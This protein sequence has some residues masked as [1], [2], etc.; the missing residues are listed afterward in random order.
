MN[1]M[2]Y[3][4][5]HNINIIPQ[6]DYEALVKETFNDIAFNITKSLGPL[7]SSAT[8][9]DGGIV[10]ATKD[11]YSILNKYKLTNVYKKMIYNLIKKPCMKMNNTVGDGTTTAIALTNHMLQIYETRTK[12]KLNK[13][14]RMPRDLIKAWDEVIAEINDRVSK[15][16]KPIDPEDHD[17]IYNIAYVTSNGNE[18]ISKAF[19]ETYKEAKSPAIKMK[20]SPTNKSY[21]KAI[22]GFEFPT[23]AIDV[24]YVKNE[25]LSTKEDNICV[26]I[27]DH[28]ITTDTFDKVIVKIN[29]VLRAKGNKLVIIAPKYDEY[30]CESIL[31]QYINMEVQRYGGVNLILTQYRTGVLQDHQLEDLAVVLHTKIMTEDLVNTITQR[32]TEQSADQIIDDMIE[33]DTYDLHRCI[34]YALSAL[35]TCKNGT[36]FKPQDIED[37]EFYINTLNIAQKELE[38]IIASTSN[39][40]QAYTS[41]IYDARSRVLQLQMKNYIYY[42]GADS[43]L[44]KQILQDAVDDVIKCLRSAIKYGVVPGCQIS[45]LQACAEIINEYNCNDNSKT[46][47]ETMK[48]L[49]TALIHESVQ[50]TYAQVLMG[51]NNNGLDPIVEKPTYEFTEEEEKA[52]DNMSDEELSAKIE[53]IRENLRKEFTDNYH[54]KIDEI[55]QQSIESGQTFD[56]CD[57]EFTD[58]IITSAQTD[59]MVLTA[60]SELIKIL[61]SGNQCIF[62]DYDKSEEESINEYNPYQ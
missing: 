10:E 50:R 39:E 37:D 34:G 6:Q 38:D 62:N 57:L 42:V 27:F 33:L 51:P 56:I 22:D 60:A 2:D 58:N 21:I 54:K 52:F 30:M 13:Y 31:R 40:Q 53:P 43:D 12:A 28:T 15:K 4:N 61:I 44:Q 1:Y 3:F 45:I 8:I 55:I 46:N 18:E 49:I 20:D 24:G 36:I 19:A 9:F 25:D 41:K 29:E 59:T 17:T 47:F 35:I 5:K 14:Y 48:V 32:L 11:G 7:G 26:M 23:N 16:A